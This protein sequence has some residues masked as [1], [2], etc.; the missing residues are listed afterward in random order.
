MRSD[1]PHD[2]E[3]VLVGGEAW[4][5]D[6][7]VRYV[8]WQTP[9]GRWSIAPIQRATFISMAHHFMVSMRTRSQAV[10]GI[11]IGSQVGRSHHLVDPRKS[12][13]PVEPRKLT[14]STTS[15]GA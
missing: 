15:H 11:R 12:G 14:W 6:L 10:L 5:N 2:G 3:E 8:R 9:V 4:A 7:K 13:A 1:Q